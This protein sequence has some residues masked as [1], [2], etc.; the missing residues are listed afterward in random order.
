MQR[1]LSQ[2]LVLDPQRRAARALPDEGA[3]ARES[4]KHV[5]ICVYIYIYIYVYV[6]IQYN[7]Y[8]FMCICIYIY[9][10]RERDNT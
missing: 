5:C 4:T 10:E 7:T 9:I 3:L 1:G 8:V 2:Q 6:Y